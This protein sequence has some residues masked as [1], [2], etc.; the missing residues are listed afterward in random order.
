MSPLISRFSSGAATLIAL[1]ALSFGTFLR[2]AGPTIAAPLSANSRT[3][4]VGR[5]L[6]DGKSM[7]PSRC[8]EFSC[9]AV[10][11]NVYEGLI[12]YKGTNVAKPIPLLAK[13]WKITNNSKVYTFQL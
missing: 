8:Y 12:T 3:L 9:V 10:M 1:V 7:D 2:P 5:F 13:S 11:T 4:V 6:G